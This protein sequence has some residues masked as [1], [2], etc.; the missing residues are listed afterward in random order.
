MNSL[1]KN[2]QKNKTIS[3]QSKNSS[4]LFNNKSIASQ[5]GFDKSS[6][7]NLMQSG[8]DKSSSY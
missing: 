3:R 4:D 7:Y 2:Y 8:F 1:F 5:K 6:P